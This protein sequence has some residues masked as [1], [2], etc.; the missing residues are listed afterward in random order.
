MGF[1][2]ALCFVGDDNCIYQLNGYAEEKI[3]PPDIDALIEDVMD[4]STLI[5][6]CYVSNGNAFWQISSSTWTRVFNLNNQKW[7]ERSSLGQTRSRMLQTVYAFGKW[8]CGDQLS[9]NLYQ[10]TNSCFQEAGG[11]LRFMV[12][13]GPVDKFPARFRVP[14]AD[15]M[16]APGTGVAT[17]DDPTVV[18]P[19]AQ[20]SWSDDGGT[21]WGNPVFRS[22]G[23]QQE[24][25][26]RVTVT[27]CGVTKYLGRRWRVIVDDPVYVSLMGGD[28]GVEMRG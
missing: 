5:A 15:F 26:T 27:R 4:K 25:E 10:I 9:G 22:I 7:H 21:S 8:L 24:A 2:Q 28:Q 17:S 18:D 13:S 16:F 14:R 20:I 3:S 1:G 12:E 11:P 19:K 23:E 6:S